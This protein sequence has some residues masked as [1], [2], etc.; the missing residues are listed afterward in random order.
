MKTNHGYTLINI[1][2]VLCI[3][4]IAA[5]QFGGMDYFVNEREATAFHNELPDAFFALA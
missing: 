4:L 2:I 3:L 1:L 5:S